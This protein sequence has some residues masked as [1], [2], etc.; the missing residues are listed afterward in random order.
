VEVFCPALKDGEILLRQRTS[1][2]IARVTGRLAIAA[3]VQVALQDG[4]W[5][6]ITD[7][8]AALCF[9]TREIYNYVQA[10][11]APQRI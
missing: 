4:R 11:T 2:R 9:Y 1:G 6:G 8:L 5:F 10:V 3:Q 7:L